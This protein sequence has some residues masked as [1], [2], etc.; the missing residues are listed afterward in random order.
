MPDLERA[1]LFESTV[2]L[3]EWASRRPLVLLLEDLHAADAAS[4]ELAGYV[5]RRVARMPALIVLTRRPL[6]RRTQVDAL[7]HALRTQRALVCEVA[8]DRLQNT[9]IARLARQVAP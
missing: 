2:A 7:E 8:L 4:L 1:R 5:G 6:P 9:Q 3:V